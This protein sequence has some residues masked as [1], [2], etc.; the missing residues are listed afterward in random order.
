MAGQP[1]PRRFQF[2]LLTLMIAVTL[3]AVICGVV[4]WDVRDRLR[5]IQERDA[6]RERLLLEKRIAAG[7]EATAER[8]DLELRALKDRAAA[9]RSANQP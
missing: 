5:M 3:V 2:R 1:T 9:S 4:E 6:A 7:W 8:K